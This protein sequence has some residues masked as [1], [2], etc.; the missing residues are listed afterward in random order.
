MKFTQECPI[1][2][3]NNI[4]GAHPVSTMLGGGIPV[5]VL[6]TGRT[7]RLRSLTC[8]TC[9]YTQIYA[10]RKGLQNLRESGKVY[11]IPDMENVY[12]PQCG[13][14]F[15]KGLRKCSKCGL[16]DVGEE[17]FIEPEPTPCEGCGLRLDYGTHTCPACGFRKPES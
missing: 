9:G 17:H 10:D 14:R 1:C 7:S 4:S 2:G 16:M 8:L 12:C 5:I 11:E 13:A 15:E 6:Q 3:S